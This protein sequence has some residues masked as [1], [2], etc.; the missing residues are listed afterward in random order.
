MRN[1]CNRTKTWLIRSGESVL[2]AKMETEHIAN[3]IALCERVRGGR[4]WPVARALRKELR[5]RQRMTAKPIPDLWR[6]AMETALH[7]HAERA[8]F[9]ISALSARCPEGAWFNEFNRLLG[10][11]LR[12]A[13]KVARDYARQARRGAHA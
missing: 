2:I 13:Q 1:H 8:A 7:E 10:A 3:S 12:R 4:R 11:E 6:L 5:R 9:T